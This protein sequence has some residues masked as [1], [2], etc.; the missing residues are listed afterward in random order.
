MFGGFR[1]TPVFIM[2]FSQNWSVDFSLSLAF[3]KQESLRG[4]QNEKGMLEFRHVR[5]NIRREFYTIVRAKD[6]ELILLMR[7]MNIRRGTHSIHTLS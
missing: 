7:A 3:S 1:K 4:K 5:V 2:D 6:D